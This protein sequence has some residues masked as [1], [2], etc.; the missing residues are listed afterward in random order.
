MRKKTYR[1]LL[2][3][4]VV[5]VLGS[6]ALAI[7]IN[8]WNHSAST[9][10]ISP[11][12]IQQT[13]ASEQAQESNSHVSEGTQPAVPDGSSFEIHFFDVGEADSALVECDGHYM[14]IDGGNPSSSSFLYSYLQKHG[15]DY[16]DYPRYG[17]QGN[18]TSSAD[19]CCFP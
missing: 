14:L 3:L 1:A 9:A 4:A 8:Y 19:P 7:G 5:V 11:A 17:H 13:Q 10:D 6:I 2:I 12:E 18:R 16:L 15:I